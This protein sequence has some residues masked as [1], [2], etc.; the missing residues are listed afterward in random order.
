M[1]PAQKRR[2]PL[3]PLL[4]RMPLLLLSALALLPRQLL[5]P[6]RQGMPLLLWRQRLWLR[7][8]P[9]RLLLLLHGLL[10]LLL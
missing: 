6:Q 1:L 2:Q 10:L 8:V 7:Q 9:W 4:L 3:P 5:Q